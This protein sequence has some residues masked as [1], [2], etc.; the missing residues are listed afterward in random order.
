[1][2][3]IYNKI[4]DNSIHK[5]SLHSRTAQIVIDELVRAWKNF[6]DYLENKSKYFDVVKLPKYMDKKSIHRTI[7][8][9]K[10][11]FKIIKENTN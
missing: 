7:T 8:Y 3:D 6:F 11:G 10:T 5:K 4:K 2:Y 9:D 1:M